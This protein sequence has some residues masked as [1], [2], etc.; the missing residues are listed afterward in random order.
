LYLTTRAK[1]LGTTTYLLLAIEKV[2]YCVMRHPQLLLWTGTVPSR[3]NLCSYTAALHA[4]PL[5][6]VAL[7]GETLT[8]AMYERHT[9]LQLLLRGLIPQ[10][11]QLLSGRT[12]STCKG[13]GCRSE[14]SQRL[15]SRDEYCSSC[16]AGSSLCRCLL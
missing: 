13:T 4:F 3:T 7:F 6:L 9:C 11:A 5:L 16:T 8:A 14:R 15:T 10:L 12:D 1:P 2:V